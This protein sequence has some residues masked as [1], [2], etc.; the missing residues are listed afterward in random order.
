[1]FHFFFRV[2]GIELTISMGL[3]M[4]FTLRRWDASTVVVEQQEQR[5]VLIV[6]SLR[7]FV[8]ALLLQSFH[9]A[10][11]ESQLWVPTELQLLSKN[12]CK[13]IFWLWWWIVKRSIVNDNNNNHDVGYG[14]V[15]FA[16]DQQ[17]GCADHRQCQPSSLFTLAK[18]R[19][20][21][22]IKLGLK[23]TSLMTA[24]CLKIAWHR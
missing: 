19:W 9:D 20:T 5:S 15:D 13:Q 4:A 16:L 11:V 8:V 6:L 22:Q 23:G 17:Y 2:F 12:V 14:L 18:T 3:E 24:Q 7:T 1:M 21:E 10:S